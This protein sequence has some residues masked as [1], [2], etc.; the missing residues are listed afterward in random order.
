M[1][2]RFGFAFAGIGYILRT[3][4]NSRIHLVAAGITIGLS[5]WLQLSRVE[6]MILVLA[7]GSVLVAEALNT[8]V[9]TVVDLVQPKDHPLAKVAKDVA[10][11]AVLIAA[12]MAL[13]VGALL[14][15]PRLMELWNPV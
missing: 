2:Q 11:G 5:V 12:I 15:V 8:A 10:A 4:I 13:V 7:I 6:W 1:I 9:E 3:Q 14:F